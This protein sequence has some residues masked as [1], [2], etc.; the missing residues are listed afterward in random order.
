MKKKVISVLLATSIAAGL[1]T[2]CGSSDSAG[3]A[4]SAASEAA[5]EA[6]AAQSEE[7]AE[8]E[9]AETSEAAAAEEE[10]AEPTP[11]RILGWNAT[12]GHIDSVI[13]YTAGYYEEE[14]IIPEFTYNNSNPDNTQALMEDK[15][16]LVSAGATCV[17]Q[18]IDQGADIV[19]I[20]GQMSLGETLYALPERAEE[21]SELTEETLAGKKIGVTRLN[22]G[23]I[24]FRKILSDRGIDLSKIEFVELDSQPTV[25]QAVLKGEVDLGINFLNYRAA[26]EEQGL[27]PVSQLDAEDEW[28]DYICCRIFTTR[29]KLEANREAYVNAMK[30]NIRAYELIE[31]DQD[32]AIDAALKGLEIEEDVLIDQMYTY[33]HLGLSPNPDV[34]NT[35]KF[36]EAMADIDYADGAVDIADYIDAS[37]YIDALNELLE[38]DPTNEVYLELKAESDATNY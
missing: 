14:G 38:E 29:E 19:I 18:Y 36:Y 17:L 3:A 11:L 4:S 13:A 32:A 5:A 30:A 20:G 2:G 7:A 22:T 1:F 8:S 25:T 27:V 9:P 35:A 10:S 31:T 23:D 28:P 37:V 12:I 16:D 33:G 24:A 34:K 15:A 26:A 21:F 6:S